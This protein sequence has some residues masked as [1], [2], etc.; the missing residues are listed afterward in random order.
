M[1]REKMRQILADELHGHEVLKQWVENQKQ[2]VSGYPIPVIG[3]DDF[4]QSL[5]LDLYIS[6]YYP[7][8]YLPYI[9]KD[10]TE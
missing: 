4:F 1:K 5:A 9:D 10:D 3:Y 6:N 8:K 7:G 2:I